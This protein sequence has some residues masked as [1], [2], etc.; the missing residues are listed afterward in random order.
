MA[1]FRRN[2][3]LGWIGIAG[4]FASEYAQEGEEVLEL[5]E[6]GGDAAEDEVGQEYRQDVIHQDPHPGGRGREGVLGGAV[7][8]HLSGFYNIIEYFI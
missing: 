8:D 6:E 4:W 2:H 3:W 7:G 5:G 1:G